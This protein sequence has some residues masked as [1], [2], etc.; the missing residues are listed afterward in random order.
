M[1]QRDPPHPWVEDVKVRR[2]GADSDK[3]NLPAVRSPVVGHDGHDPLG[4]PGP[5]GGNY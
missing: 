1:P 5:E 3:R 4:A 2:L